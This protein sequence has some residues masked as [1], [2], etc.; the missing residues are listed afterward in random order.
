MEQLAIIPILGFLIIAHELGHFIAARVSGVVVE[1]FAVGFPPRLGS[2]VQ[3]GIRYSL[4]LIPFGAYVRLLGEEDPSAPGSFAGKSKSARALI[5]GAGSGMNLIVAMLAFALAYG[6]GWPDPSAVVV[7]IAE[8]L[9]ESPGHAGGLRGG[10]VV[11][12]M[13]GA[14]IQGPAELRGYVQGKLGQPVRVTVEREQGT[15]ELTVVP[16]T[17]WPEGQG[18][19]GIRLQARALPVP[20]DPVSSLIFGARQTL[21][22][23][24]LTVIAPALAIRGEL[25]LEVVR[26]IGIPGMTQ[27]AAEATTAVVESGWLFPVLVLAG[28]FSAGLA[29]A[30]MLPFPALDG[31][32]LLFVAIEAIRGRRVA[33]EREGLIHA[34]GLMLLL[35]LMI[36]IS[37][38]DVVQPLPAID[39]GLP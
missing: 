15:R 30:N 3:G 13:D 22:V 6:T 5:L 1:E 26:P 39:W 9:P 37:F 33:P 28:V 20:H 32:R 12:A 29:A 34:A 11:R 31:G 10:D 19:L 7:R 21:Q 25:P 17:E 23:V 36:L 8:V 14:V 18:P 4:N 38:Y 35:S 2:V 16:R 24:G 27:L